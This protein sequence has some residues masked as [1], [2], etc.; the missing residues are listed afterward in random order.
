MINAEELAE[1]IANLLRKEKGIKVVHLDDDSD[2]VSLMTNDG[3]YF[4]V[5]VRK[6]K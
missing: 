4:V 3:H 5:D 2:E 1:R 6:I